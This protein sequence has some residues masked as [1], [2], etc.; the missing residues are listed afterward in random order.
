MFACLLFFFCIYKLASGVS[1]T[2]TEKPG[3]LHTRT[4][5]H[6]KK[7]FSKPKFVALVAAAQPHFALGH[8]AKKISSISTKKR[9]KDARSSYETTYTCFVFRIPFYIMSMGR[10]WR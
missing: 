8:A 3:A 7:L 6:Q 4:L 9:E 5:M 1:V 2:V 10:W